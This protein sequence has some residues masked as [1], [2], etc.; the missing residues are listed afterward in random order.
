[1]AQ[2]IFSATAYLQM[3]DYN[4]ITVDWGKSAMHSFYLIM[5]HRAKIVGIEISKL[6]DKLVDQHIVTSD[7]IHLIGHSVGA[8]A[9]GVAGHFAKSGKVA[10]ITG[11]HS[12]TNMFHHYINAFIYKFLNNQLVFYEICL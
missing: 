10:R 11:K 8:H 6:I 2:I 9:M 5:I 4:I 12:Y 1:M 7:Q 3:H